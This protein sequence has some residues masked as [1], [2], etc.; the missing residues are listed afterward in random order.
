MNSTP[1][2][3]PRRR[4]AARRVMSASLS[5]ALAVLLSVT[6]GCTRGDLPEA[7][8]QPTP[9]DTAQSGQALFTNGSF[10]EGSL[11]GWSRLHP[12]QSRHHRPRRRARRTS[13]SRAEAPRSP[14]PG[15][16]PEA[17]RARFPP[18]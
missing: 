13:T 4:T 9:E 14:S 6:S 16:R 11:N 7:S 2:P 5:T 8:A 15:T 10:E 18:A 3:T 17:R 12:P 1:L